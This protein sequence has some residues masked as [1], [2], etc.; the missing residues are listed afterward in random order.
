MKLSS[1]DSFA[2]LRI[3][4]DDHGS[5]VEPAFDED[6]PNLVKLQWQ[7]AVVRERC[8]GLRITFM[9]QPHYPGEYCVTVPGASAVSFTFAEAWTLV[10]GIEMGYQAAAGG[11][12]DG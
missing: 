3:V 11:T 9:E 4:E 10:N 12:G 1:N 8:D 5:H 7:A 2:E 6:W